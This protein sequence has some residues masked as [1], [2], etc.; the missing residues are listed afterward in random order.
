M[1]WLSSFN[2]ALSEDMSKLMGAF[3]GGHTRFLDMFILKYMTSLRLNC[4]VF[5]VLLCLPFTV[6]YYPMWSKYGNVIS[7]RSPTA[8]VCGVP[9]MMYPISNRSLV[10]P[11]FQLSV[12][13]SAD[14]ASCFHVAVAQVTVYSFAMH[15]VVTS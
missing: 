12:D 10:T 15:V 13:A 7:A 5:L 8:C 3:F 1:F 14:T 9:D 6:Y 4:T 11:S 2:V